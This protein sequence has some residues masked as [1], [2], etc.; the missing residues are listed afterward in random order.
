M[1]HHGNMKWLILTITALFFLFEFVTRIEPSLANS[2]IAARFQLNNAQF[3]TLASIFFWIYAP[4]QLIVGLLLDRFGARRLIPPAILVCAGG[5]ILF[6]TAGNA[7]IAGIGRFATGLGASFAF[8]GSLYVVNHWF[9]AGRFALLSGVVNAV[10]MLGTAIGA[11][12]LTS[13]IATSGWQNVFW[14]T[15]IAGLVLFVIAL[16][17][18]RDPPEHVP[19]SKKTT[20][21]ITPVRVAVRD[22]HI[23]L[24][25]VIGTLYYMPINVFGGLWG[26]AELTKDHGLSP[27]HAETAVS[28]IFWGLAAGSIAAGWLSDH[29]GH[30]KWIIVIGAFLTSISFTAAV[31]LPTSSVPLLS[32]LLFLS[33]FLGGGQMLTFSIAKERHTADYSGTIIAFVN[34]IGIGGAL[35][36]Q[37]LVGAIV[38]LN[39]GDFAWAM[40]TMPACLLS[41]ALLSLLLIDKRHPDHIPGR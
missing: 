24:I 3:G 27:V 36:F 2:E 31:Y 20:S 1:R 13:V 15:G 10:G 12:A 28:M 9:G 19:A 11:V 7:Y 17:F 18:M 37:P 38:D 33:G 6:A 34:M 41:A 30:R 14:A 32:A 16:L 4:M 40:L 21:F 35:I 25:A 26:N 39:N 8:V 29:L 22:P 23:W 5:V